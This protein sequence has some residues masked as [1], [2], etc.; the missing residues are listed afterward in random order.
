[1]WVIIVVKVDPVELGLRDVSEALR[2]V[3][4]TAT[5]NRRVTLGNCSNI[6]LDRSGNHFN[7]RFKLVSHG[8]KCPA[9]IVPIIA[10][11]TASRKM[12]THL[13]WK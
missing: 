13:L 3:P 12:G 11:D 7:K 4:G 8:G 10:F 2:A 1:M 6:S 5:K 9:H